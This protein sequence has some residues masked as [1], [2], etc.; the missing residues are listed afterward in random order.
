VRQSVVGWRTFFV[1]AL[2]QDVVAGSPLFS[3]GRKKTAAHREQPFCHL[4]ESDSTNRNSL[5]FNIRQ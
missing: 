3:S 2:L 4:Q 1:P 5:L